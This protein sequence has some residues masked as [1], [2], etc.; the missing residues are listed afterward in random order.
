MEVEKSGTQHSTKEKL[1]EIGMPLFAR[2]GYAGTT[3]RMISD[4][5]EINLNA[6]QFHFGGKEGLYRSILEH[7]AQNIEES[8]SDINDEIARSVQKGKMSM[9]T[10]REFISKLIDLQLLHVINEEN[11]ERLALMYWEQLEPQSSDHM[12]ISTIVSEKI[13]DTLAAL[14]CAANPVLPLED[15]AIVSR[16]INGAVISFGE[17]PVFLENIRNKSIYNNYKIHICEIIKPMIMDSI[18]RLLTNNQ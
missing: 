15:A 6:I 18:E 7:V 2:Y 11:T 10:I 1:I 8:Y 5:A 4:A 9:D 16:F 12:P 17:H 14:L 13:E 3:T